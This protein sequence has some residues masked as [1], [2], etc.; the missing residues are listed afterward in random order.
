MPGDL[1][2]TYRQFAAFA[3]SWGS[4]PRLLFDALTRPPFREEV[5]W[6]RARFF[7]VDERCVPPE[8]ERSNYR[9]ARQ[10]LLEPLEIPSDRV[11]RMRGEGEPDTAAREYEDALDAEFG[12]AGVA[13]RF[14]FV[15][16][17]LGA[18]GHTASLFPGTA[19]LLEE[20][21]AVVANHVPKLGEW[22]LTLTLPVLNAARH[23][24]FLVTGAE[25][26]EAVAAVT[27][28]SYACSAAALFAFDCAMIFSW[29]D[30][31]ASA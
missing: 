11:V 10:H 3:L 4:T 5:A 7:F 27:K 19:A 23:A 14:D 26:S 8:H 13:P 22:R 20:R 21:R 30:C 31:G 17:G 15:L 12:G 2:S 18:D 1:S 9:M 28:R 29:I 24:I 16:L 25:K 6:S